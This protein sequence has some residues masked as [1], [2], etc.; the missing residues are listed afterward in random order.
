MRKEEV[1]ARNRVFIMVLVCLTFIMVFTLSQDSYVVIPQNNNPTWSFTHIG[2]HIMVYGKLTYL[3][4]ISNS[5]S[6]G[7][8]YYAFSTDNC[9]YPEIIAS[10]YDVFILPWVGDDVLFKVKHISEDSDS[11]WTWKYTIRLERV[12]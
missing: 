11:I 8:H 7:N 12:N 2:N 9:S 10:P 5:G 1:G 4:S 3:S 6:G